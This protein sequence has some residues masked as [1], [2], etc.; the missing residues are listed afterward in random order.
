M[1][2]DYGDAHCEGSTDPIGMNG[3]YANAQA[4][5]Y[6]QGELGVKV[7][8]WFIKARIPI[9]QGAAAALM[10]ASLP[11]PAWFVGYLG[12]RFNLLGGMVKGNVRFKVEVGNECKIVS[13]QVDKQRR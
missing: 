3:W 1:L 9:I 2:K 4:Y 7:N 5:A 11:N 10:Q 12:V 8:L 6:L 13:G